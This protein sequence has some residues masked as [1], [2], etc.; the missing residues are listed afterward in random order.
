MQNRPKS[1]LLLPALLLMAGCACH[2]CLYRNVY[3]GLQKREEIVQPSDRPAD[4]PP[5]G[6]DAYAR[7]QNQD[8]TQH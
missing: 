8:Q 6:Y 5:Q 3:N 7:E 2:E 4:Q 1:W